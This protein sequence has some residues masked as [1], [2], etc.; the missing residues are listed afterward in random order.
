MDVVVYL[1]LS[2]YYQLGIQI[3]CAILIVGLYFAQVRQRLFAS[4][5][6]A[7]QL[8]AIRAAFCHAKQ[9]THRWLSRLSS[10]CP[11]VLLW[12][13]H[14]VFSLALWA[15]T[16]K[17]TE[18]RIKY[19]ATRSSVGSFTHTTHLFAWSAALTRSLA[20]L[21]TSLTPSLVRIWIIRWLF[22]LCF[23]PF[24]TIVIS[25]LDAVK[26]NNIFFCPWIYDDRFTLT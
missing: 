4:F 3:G 6:I 23:F 18:Y 1:D 19:W 12:M 21:L 7:M 14:P 10:V 17:N 8:G 24:S 9:R 11:F 20:R 15:R 2:G 26:I 25:L 5:P 22:C 13:C 16:T